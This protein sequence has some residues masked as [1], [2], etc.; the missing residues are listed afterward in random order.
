MLFAKVEM[1][2]KQAPMT[3][4][5]IAAALGVAGGIAAGRYVNKAVGA[6]IAAGLVGWA[7]SAVIKSTVLKDPE[8]AAASAKVSGF[9]QVSDRDLLLGMGVVDNDVSVSD[10]RPLPGQTDGLS[11]DAM[12]VMDYRPMPGQTDGLGQAGDVYATDLQPMPGVSGR[13]GYMSGLSS[14]IS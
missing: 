4:A 7:V 8:V 10:Y 5:G 14:F 13:S 11:G 2:K 6:G 3:Q 12:S 9:G 1:L